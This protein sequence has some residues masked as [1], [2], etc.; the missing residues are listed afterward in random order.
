MVDY[1]CNFRCRQGYVPLFN[2]FV[3]C[4][5]SNSGLR[6]LVTT[7]VKSGRRVEPRSGAYDCFISFL[8]VFSSVHLLMSE[9]YAVENRSFP[10]S[11]YRVAQNKPDYSNFQPCL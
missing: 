5:S 7:Y 10:N 11:I 1:W 3:R 4:E 2:A 6:N 8:T 9:N